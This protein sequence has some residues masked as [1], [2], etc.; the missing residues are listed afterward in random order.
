MSSEHR[1][2]SDRVY[3]VKIWLYPQLNRFGSSSRKN[4]RF[5][6]LLA[7]SYKAYDQIYSKISA[8]RDV[9]FVDRSEIYSR[10]PGDTIHFD[11]ICEFIAAYN[12]ELI[13]K[14]E[15]LEK[16]LIE[17]ALKVPGL[18]PLFPAPKTEE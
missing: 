7:N 10:E 1:R 4:G 5:T 12:K 14:V 6:D 8:R 13:D 18:T 2:S 16:T 15:Q 3:D 11:E 9:A 17:N